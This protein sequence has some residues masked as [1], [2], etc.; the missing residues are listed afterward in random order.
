MKLTTDPMLVL[1]YGTW[2]I[3]DKPVVNKAGEPVEYVQLLD[4][5]ADE[6]H[7]L[8]LRGVPLADRPAP[9]N[10]GVATCEGRTSHKG[11]EDGSVNA[12]L[13]LQVVALKKA[14]APSSV[15]S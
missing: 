13:K 8:S 12:R 5:D 1:G 2:E 14:S 15:K 3:D 6:I 7:R 10:Y 9:M 11:R 4:L